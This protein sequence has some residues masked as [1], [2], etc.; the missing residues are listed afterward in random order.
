[1]QAYKFHIHI[2]YII[3]ILL[4]DQHTSK[5]TTPVNL[6]FQR[7]ILIYYEYGN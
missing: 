5:T 1:M 3:Q 4:T 6:K 7:N 2:I